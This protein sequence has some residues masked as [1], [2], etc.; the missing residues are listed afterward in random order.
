MAIFLNLKTGTLCKL[1]D[2]PLAIYTVY[3][4]NN[5]KTTQTR[6]TAIE[7]SDGKA[8]IFRNIRDTLGTRTTDYCNLKIEIDVFVFHRYL[9]F[10]KK[11]EKNTDLLSYL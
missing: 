9:K 8:P 6:T 2:S 5:K 7:P 4:K 10:D 1:T 11:L 3:K